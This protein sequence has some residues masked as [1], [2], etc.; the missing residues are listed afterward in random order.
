LHAVVH[1]QNSSVQAGLRQGSRGLHGCMRRQQK[2]TGTPMGAPV[3][4]L[5]P[6]SLA[7]LR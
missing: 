4:F 6:I 5:L 7:A 2:A 1:T 3:A